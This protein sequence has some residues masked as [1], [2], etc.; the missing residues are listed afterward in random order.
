LSS[1]GWLQLVTRQPAVKSFM[2]ATRLAPAKRGVFYSLGLSLLNQGQIDLAIQAMTLEIVRDPLWLTSPV[3]GSPGLVT[4]TPKVQTSVASLYLQ[5]LQGPISTA[6]RTYLHQCLGGVYWW[7][8]KL[9]ESAVEWKSHGS[10][11]SQQLLQV[12]QGQVS[13]SALTQPHPGALILRAWLEPQQ[14]A[15]NIGQAL[16]SANQ[17]QPRSD[18]VQTIL[19]GMAQSK[20]LDEWI[21]LHAPVTQYRRERAGFG[22]LSRHIDGP[23]PQDF[24]EVVDNTAMTTFFSE[25][26]PSVPYFPE[27]DLSLQ[28]LRLKLWQ[29]IE[30]VKS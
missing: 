27:L 8:G 24:F 5:L 21:K 18:Q 2:A 28:P 11:L 29:A 20:S 1:L 25:I 17:T 3:W 13:P 15:Q 4:V 19:Q 10:P 14:R 22:V 23:A 26:L 16:L 9:R 7:Q 30:H 6:Y 12:A